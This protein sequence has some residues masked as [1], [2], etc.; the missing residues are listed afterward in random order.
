MEE[1]WSFGPLRL[2]PGAHRLSYSCP[3]LLSGRL[4]RAYDVLIASAAADISLETLTDLG[5][6]GLGLFLS[7]LYEAIIMPG[8]QKP[9]CRPCFSQKPSWIG[10]KLPSGA[11]PSIVVTSLPSA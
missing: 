4:D 1:I 9:H 2:L 3:H 10:C 8:V 5:L 6:C 7:R 11:R